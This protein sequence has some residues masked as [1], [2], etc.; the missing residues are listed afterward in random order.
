MCTSFNVI[1]LIW[2]GSSPLK[3]SAESLNIV[4]ELVNE[5]VVSGLLLSSVVEDKHSFAEVLGFSSLAWDPVEKPGL[6]C[7]NN[8]ILF[9]YNVK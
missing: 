4:Q 7:H 8:I 2:L 1:L 3:K 9:G 6:P 5:L